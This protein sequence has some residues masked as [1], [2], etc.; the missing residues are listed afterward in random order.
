MWLQ[1]SARCRDECLYT[2]VLP[3]KSQTESVWP[4]DSSTISGSYGIS[5][6]FAGGVGDVVELLGLHDGGVD[7]LVV[8]PASRKA[9]SIDL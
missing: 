3:P 5:V 6:T 8:E 4:V 7:R 1:L 9:A 2:A